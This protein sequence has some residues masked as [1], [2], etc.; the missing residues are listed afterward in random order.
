MGFAA[1]AF[2]HASDFLKSDDLHNTSCLIADMRM[3]GMTG[4]E[5]HSRLVESGNKIPTILITAFPDDRDRARARQSG[6][7]CYLSKPYEDKDLLKCVLSAL[8]FSGII[9][10]RVIRTAAQS[11][12]HKPFV[13]PHLQPPVRWACR[14]MQY[15]GLRLPSRSGN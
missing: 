15:E 7:R 2:P 3:P 11:A 12:W 4:L 10:S 5:L 6:V 14:P 9:V 13:V 8:A 1:K